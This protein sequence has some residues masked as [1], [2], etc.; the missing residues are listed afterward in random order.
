MLYVAWADGDLTPKEI[1]AISSRL[2]ATPGVDADCRDFLA[3]W[4]DPDQPPSAAALGALLSSIRQAAL[5]LPRRQRRTLTEFGL[6]LAANA[7]IEILEPELEALEKLEEALGL[8]GTEATRHL[9]E[10]ARPDAGYDESP[11][12]FDVASMTQLLDGEQGPVR[13]WLREI[14]SRPD[15][16]YVYGLDLQTYREQVLVWARKLAAEGVGSL[17]YPRQVGGSDDFGAFVAAFETLAFHDLS[18]LI[19][20]GVQFG[21]FGGSIL[22]LG[23]ERHHHKYLQRV[24]GLELPGCFAMTE[25][26]HGSNVHELG[27]VAR[28]DATTEEF[29]VHT[30]DQSARKDYIG[31]AARDGRLATVFAQL[32]VGEERHGVH[33]LL[34][35]IRD[36]EVRFVRVYGSRTAGRSWV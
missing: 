14:L 26:G 7:N 2:E 21:L 3:R 15:F 9:L 33:A 16:A 29:V 22:Q 25:T 8:T 6:E 24:G 10:T 5:P 17:T 13:A 20:M 18:L 31:N 11:P 32:E 19:K 23:T 28:Y 12:V 1:R 36:A 27:T 34:V 30:P 35:P 4:L